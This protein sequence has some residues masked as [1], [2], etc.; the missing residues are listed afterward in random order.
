MNIKGVFVDEKSQHSTNPMLNRKDPWRSQYPDSV[1]PKIDIDQYKNILEVFDQA[2]ARY[3]DKKS[4]SNF[5]HSYSF[6]QLSEKVDHFSAFLQQE[7]KLKKG[8]RIAIQIPN[9]LQYP[10]VLFGA[11]KAG[12]II[13]NINPLYTAQ[14]MKHQFKD[15][16]AKCIV[17]LKNYAHLL[18]SVIKDTQIESVVVTEIGDFL[19][20]PKNILIN[21]V[22]KYVKKMVPTFHLPQQAY[23]LN[24]AMEIGR[25]TTFQK[26]EMNQLDIVF[27][28]Y[29]GGTTGV[30]KGAILTH[31][32]II[33]NILQICNWMRPKLKEGEEIALTPLPL[34]HIFSLTVNCLAFMR[35]GAQNILITNPRDIPAFIKE[36]KSSKY[37]VM[38]GVNT[39]YNGLM[40]HPDFNTI[41]FSQVKINVA[42]AMAL[43]KAV[44]EKW[45]K[46]TKTKVVEGYGLT[47]TSPV[48]CCNPIDGTDRVGTI[49]LPVPDTWIKFVDDDGN[50]VIEEPG[51]ICVYGPQVMK[52]YW[53]RPDETAK[54]IDKE[55]WFHTGDIGIL[56][57]KGFVKIVDRKKDM[58]LVS[59]FN[60]YPNEVEDAIASHPGVLEVAAIGVPD[61]HSGEIVKVVVVKK[62]PSLT[63]AVI[64]EHAKKSLT[65][66]KVPKIVEFRKELPKT[67]V[68]KILRRALRQN[69]V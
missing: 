13:V 34:Y 22:I 20:F 63:E 29:T 33:A 53:E 66:Y 51:E 59:G 21:F 49:G 7:L 46:L 15:S 58:I 68:G 61:Q 36:M 11:M 35:Y 25:L 65:N 14:E 67:N 16:G 4:F 62:D 19:P 17:I 55:G 23:E 64:I 47:E 69:P 27:L 38:S 54:V 18:E 43:Q 31:R 57:E 32:N 3:T 40:N 30:S 44:S 37:T 9:L 50:E 10:V 52:G 42:G 28:Q 1:S 48:A 26:V 56:D 5:G 12:L 39:L 24:Q 2:V 45:E 60:V 8:D 6:K 41:D